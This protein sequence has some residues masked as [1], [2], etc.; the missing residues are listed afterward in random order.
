MEAVAVINAAGL[1]SFAL[2]FT[3]AACRGALP[4]GACRWR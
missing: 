1:R 2:D 3:E 4:V